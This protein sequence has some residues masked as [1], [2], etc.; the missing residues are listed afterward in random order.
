MTR[1]E[2]VMVAAVLQAG[3]PDR[4]VPRAT[5]DLWYEL[6]CDLPADPVLAAVKRYYAVSES[7]NL[8]AIGRIR[9]DAIALM[10]NSPPTAAEAWGRVQAEIRR[11][12]WYSAPDG[13]DPIT[14]RV[15]D[16]IGWQALC[17]STQP[18]V[19]RAH[20]MRMFADLADDPEETVPAG[21]RR[22]SDTD[23]LPG[24]IQA[25]LRRIGTGGNTRLAQEGWIRSHERLRV[26]PQSLY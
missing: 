4:A 1:R 26:H 14:R 2:F 19:D 9:R 5:L 25:G 15:V 17:E 7:T 8:P 10:G 23:A 20:F 6:L 21:L 22:R 3:A 11:V 16:Q 24:S 13:L 18:A 12:G